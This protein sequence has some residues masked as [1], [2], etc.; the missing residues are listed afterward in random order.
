MEE[1]LHK[2]W[3][4]ECTNWELYTVYTVI[5]TRKQYFSDSSYMDAIH[6]KKQVLSRR[7]YTV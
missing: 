7:E 3:R 6:A 4:K 2:L 1:G 5:K